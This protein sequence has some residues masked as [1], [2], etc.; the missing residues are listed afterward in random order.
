M[1]RFL[2]SGAFIASAFAFCSPA[3]AASSVD[4]V[5]ITASRIDQPAYAVGGSFSIITGEELEQRQTQFIG[6]AL[7]SVPG[8]AVNRSGSFGAQTQLRIRGAESNMT[9]VLIDGVKVNAPADFG[10][11]FD[12]GNLVALD[13]DRIEVLRGAQSS[14]WGSNAI[15][16]VV[17]IVTKEPARGFHALAS[18]EGGSFD[19]TNYRARIAYGAEK[20]GA[21]L[22]GSLFHTN[23]ISQADVKF[24]AR[25]RDGNRNG[26][27]NGRIKIAPVDNLTITLDGRY[28][29][30]KLDTDSSPPFDSDDVTHLNERW[31]NATADWKLFDGHVQ[32]IATASVLDIKANSA[33]AAGASSFS[34]RGAKE[35]Y[36][37][38][39]NLTADTNVLVPAKHRLTLLAEYERDTGA[40]ASVSPFFSS[41]NPNR[42]TENRGYVAEYSV[43]LFDQLFL[44]ASAR[45]DDNNRFAD[46]WTYRGTA[47]F[48]IPSTGT[49]FHGSYGTG[50]ESPTFGD[51]FG[52]P[53]FSLPNLA[54]QPETSRSIDF[55]IEQ[56]LFA[57]RLKVDI[58]A[59][60]NR[61][62]NR[63]ATVFFN[64]PVFGPS[65]HSDNVAGRTKVEGIE[66]TATALITADLTLDLSYTYMNTQSPAG[67]ELIRRPRN[68]GSAYLN[69]AVPQWRANFNLGVAYQGRSRDTDF[70]GLSAG[71]CSVFA[72]PTFPSPFDVNLRGST[73]VTLAGSYDVTDYL[74]LHARVENALDQRYEQVVYYGSPRIAAYGGLTLKFGE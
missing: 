36:S 21:S 8:V 56:R 45:R 16:G 32:N 25:E 48:R 63:I 53:G 54:L 29:N 68:S 4:E 38:Q 23:G 46:T 44:S 58:T 22:G 17:N 71:S 1:S 55:G 28:V 35:I 67:A 69:Y 61:I 49:R 34:N 51:I 62:D 37:D 41:A 74:Q 39:V 20:F 64:D 6:D 31:G 43:G 30:S 40:S 33:S 19:T 65:F 18:F 2:L 24:G 42:V 14:I 11:D 9:L 59:F 50:V 73:L 12:F 3:F 15:G 13:V 27:A 52:F 72:P 10:N 66:L 7:R 5:L 60:Q 57:N 47:S 70:C 26:T